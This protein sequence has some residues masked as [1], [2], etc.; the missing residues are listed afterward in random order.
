MDGVQKVVRNGVM[1]DENWLERT[2]K[3]KDGGEEIQKYVYLLEVNI[4]LHNGFTIP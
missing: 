1:H 2:I 3:S 4:T